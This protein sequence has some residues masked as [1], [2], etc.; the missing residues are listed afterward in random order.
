MF[1]FFFSSH[2]CI[3]LYNKVLK[4][5]SVKSEKALYLKQRMCFEQCIA[6]QCCLSH[7]NV[8]ICYIQSVLGDKGTLIP[9]DKDSLVDNFKYYFRDKMSRIGFLQLLLEMCFHNE[10]KLL[11]IVVHDEF[12][13]C[14]FILSFMAFPAFQ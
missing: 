3:K 1:L 6:T 14:L 4:N 8:H 10:I 7:S 9:L 11:L 12:G 5:G 13:H 2:Q